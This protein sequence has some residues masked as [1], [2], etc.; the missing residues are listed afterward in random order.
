[1][2]Q[3]SACPDVDR[4]R[5]L[6]FDQSAPEEKQLLLEHLEGCDACAQQYEALP[7]QDMLVDLLRQARTPAEDANEEQVARLVERL[8][9][10]GADET[11]AGPLKE[12][13]SPTGDFA[14]GLAP[15]ADDE[16]F[17][18]LRPAQQ[19]DELGRLGAYRILK[20]LGAGGMGMVFLAEDT[21]LHRKVAL[22]TM[23]PQ[24]AESAAAKE[25]FLREA[26]SAASIEHEHIVVIHQVGEDNGVPFLAMPFLKGEPLDVRLYR[27]GKLPLA[28]A[29]R[30]A[31]E[32]AEGLAAAHASNL[33]HRDVKPGN[34]WLES[35]SPRPTGEKGGGEGRSSTLAPLGRGVGG[36]GGKV[37]L[38]DFGLAR[39]QDDTSHLTQTGAIVGTPAYMA[40]EQAR[41]DKID[42]RADLFSLGCVLYQMLT[43]QRPFRGKDT[44][45]VLLSLATDTPSTPTLLTPA[46]PD[47]VSDLTMRL[48]AK[49]PAD[50]PASAAEVAETLR[51]LFLEGTQQDPQQRLA[52]EPATQPRSTRRRRTPVLL[53][54]G[55]LAVG[56]VVVAAMA[57]IRIGGE[58]G[59]YVIET[60]DPDISFKVSN[61]VV[62]VI[63]KAK[64]R[65]TL[66]VVQDKVKFVLEVTDPVNELVFT[67]DTF[68][69]KR[70]DK[71]ALRAWF[72]RKPPALVAPAAEAAW[73]KQVAA[74]KVED[75][76]AAVVA[77]LK[78]LNPVFDGKVTHKIEQGEVVELGMS[79]RIKDLSPVRALTKLRVFTCSE[80]PVLDLSPLKGMKLTELR[81]RHT[82]VSDLSPLKGMK[83]THL[84]CSHTKVTDL[85][86]LKD[87]P[88]K[89]LFCGGTKVSDLS[90]LRGMPLTVVACEST[91]VSD[92][93]PLKDMKLTLLDCRSTRVSDLS[94]LKGMP[95][96]VLAC[97]STPVSDLSP[98]KDMKP[99]SLNCR[100]TQVSD[101]SPLK[102]MPLKELL[103]DF[104]PERDAEILRSLKTLEKINEKPAA[105]FWKEV[106]SRDPKVEK[107]SPI[108]DAW[109]KEVAALP[110]DK[111]VD[112]VAAKL[113]E[114]NP[115]FDGN[116]THKIEQA[117]VVE[118]GMSGR[119]K[120]LSPV[121]ALTALRVL[122]CSDAPL[123]DLS[124]LKGMKLTHLSCKKT[125]V[126]DLSPLTGM[127]LTILDCSYT[128]VLDLSPLKGT[129]LT[130][131]GCSYTQVSDL[132]PLKGMPLTALFCNGLKVSDLSPLKGM[133]LADL[134]CEATK[135]NDLSPLKDTKLT[136]LSCWGT[137]V[138][139]LSPLKGMKLT[140]LDCRNTPVTDLSPL[141]GTPLKE[142]RCDFKP[143]RDAEVLR[144]IKTLE[145]IND[146]PAAEFWKEVDAGK[147]DRKP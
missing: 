126:S 70:G 9:K 114:R 113:K 97:E 127:P 77:R 21:L 110:A 49:K 12:N 36:E 40:P 31:R 81:Y 116:L 38:L 112:A 25:R 67:T 107:P 59:D 131:L 22:K 147:E 53:A 88:L 19:P 55:A 27:E 73:L 82:Q 63:D 2:P 121:R 90:P 44:Y 96:T 86:P 94:P 71:V 17:D 29:L 64:R 76:V 26:R 72:E 61:G 8:S 105:D 87:M 48:L 123:S 50:R 84:D 37:K 132:S 33:I 143:E 24:Y 146:K 57:L 32:M 34:V 60:D 51:S 39:A 108:P 11:L 133:P 69:I 111:Q 129:P 120:D 139:D 119:I 125:M 124:P 92:L 98:L 54:A 5:Q 74:M 75:Q 42:G 35:A 4:Y 134:A 68:A 141:K 144:S 136:G 102:D 65:Y 135:V 16:V 18:F 83:L 66:K 115:G 99:T 6:A 89:E 142:L 80:T 3:V 58:R 103:C 93:S 10:M 138:S 62:T 46:V 109:F 28:E 79:G 118:L 15:A 47:A 137:P 106:D 14:Q 52:K 95:L 104:K 45:S 20:K 30:I 100:N 122:N 140:G 85:S 101:L 117:E 91:P 7:N 128:Q 145:K 1:M 23:L 130:I 41:Q 13:T 43:G 78:E 56:L